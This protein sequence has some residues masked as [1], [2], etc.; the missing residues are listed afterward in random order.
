MS[1]PAA[2]GAAARAPSASPPRPSVRDPVLSFRLLDTPPAAGAW[3]MA[4]DHALLEAVAD[5]APSVLRF[6]RWE[7]A[8]L[9]LGRNQPARDRYDLAALA[10]RGLEVVR[11]PTG[12]RAVLHARELTY[13][14]VLPVAALGGPRR[15]YAAVHRALVRGL[16][17]LGVPAELQARVAGRAPPPSLAPCFREPAEGEVVAAGR[18]LVGSAQRRERGALLQHGSLL[19]ADDQATLAALL[20]APAPA[21]PDGAVATLADFLR[22]PPPWEELTAALAR[23]WRDELDLAL[24]PAEPSPAERT[25]AER[26]AALY[27]D[28]AWTWRL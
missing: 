5:G 15:T 23:G 24:A 6:Y 13:S 4:L 22:P 1:A 18:K 26:L 7:P 14:V 12:G 16:R 8:C 2:G 19:L 3:N 28:P 27:R 11:R 21:T 20:R 10:E 9:S 25:R 17:S